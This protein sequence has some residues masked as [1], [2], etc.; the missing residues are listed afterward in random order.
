MHPV[1]ICIVCLCFIPY[2]IRYLT[3]AELRKA[4]HAAGPEALRLR[5]ELTAALGLPLTVADA[6]QRENFELVFDCVDFDR[7]GDMSLKEM[8]AFVSD[9]DFLARSYLNA[10]N[11]TPQHVRIGDPPPS[12]EQAARIA[13]AHA[14]LPPEVLKLLQAIDVNR[15]GNLSQLEIVRAVKLHPEIRT[16]LKGRHAA[17]SKR[18]RLRRKRE[19]AAEVA[20]MKQAEKSERRQGQEQQQEPAQASY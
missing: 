6:R 10:F 19:Q 20:Q 5:R 15:D 13:S 17:A 1:I 4:L 16:L 8:V 14:V 18:A 3:R 9:C 12:V 2:D 11:A 7:S